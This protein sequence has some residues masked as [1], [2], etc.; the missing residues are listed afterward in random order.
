[1]RVNDQNLTGA[2]VGGAGR[3]NETERAE[4]ASGASARAAGRGDRVELSTGMG[5]LSRALASD[6]S[7]RSE[8]VRELAAQYQAGRYRPDAAQTSRAIVAEALGPAAA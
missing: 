2:S 4:R 7:G 5:S 8:K 3:T 1:M 6:Q